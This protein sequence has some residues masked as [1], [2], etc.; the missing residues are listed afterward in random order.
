M[1]SS[2]CCKHILCWVTSF[3]QEIFVLVIIVSCFIF[4]GVLGS[5]KRKAFNDMVAEIKNLQ[6]T[7]SDLL[8]KHR[9]LAREL[10]KHQDVDLK[11]KAKLKYLRGNFD[12]PSIYTSN[13]VLFVELDVT[14]F[15]LVE[16]N[17]LFFLVATKRTT[18]TPR[19]N[20]LVGD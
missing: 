4:L 2:V 3:L 13:L 19:Q 12:H 17:T 5:C 16:I 14:S 18:R 10:R 9:S 6:S 20:F 7:L 1:V 15:S 11:N 8:L